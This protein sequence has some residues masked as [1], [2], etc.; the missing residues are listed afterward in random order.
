MSSRIKVFRRE[1]G[2]LTAAFPFTDQQPSMGVPVG[3]AYRMCKE[4]L[5]QLGSDHQRDV[6]LANL[7]KTFGVTIDN[8]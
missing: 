4:M 3:Q 5:E 2:K 7:I 8:S 6:V 1:S